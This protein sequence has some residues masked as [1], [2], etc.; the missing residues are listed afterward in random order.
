MEMVMQVSILEIWIYKKLLRCNKAIPNE[1]NYV[2]VLDFALKQNLDHNLIPT[3]QNSFVNR[4]TTI[5]TT[6]IIII[7]I[8]SYLRVLVKTKCSLQQMGKTEVQEWLLKD[9]D[10][11]APRLTYICS[12]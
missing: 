6:I 7:I 2:G 8:I 5:P 11:N 10:G 4:A 9:D 3:R 12:P 1:R